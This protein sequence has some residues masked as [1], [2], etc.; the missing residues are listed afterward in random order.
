LE[1]NLSAK[2]LQVYLLR[3]SQKVERISVKQFVL[4][5]KNRAIEEQKAFISVF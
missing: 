5:L 4:L 1:I 2:T 3:A